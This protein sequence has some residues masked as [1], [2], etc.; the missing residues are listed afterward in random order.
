M[1]SPATIVCAHRGASRI[2]P[3]NSLAAFEAAIA[4]GAEMIETDVRAD[5]SGRLVL[6]HDPVSARDAGL[7]TLAELLELARGRIG[8]DLELKEPPLVEAVL[9][10]TTARAGGLMVPSCS[11]GGLLGAPAIDPALRTGLLVARL[12]RVDP[13]AAAHA[14]GASLL[15]VQESMLGDRL[16]RRADLPLWVWTVND[17]ARLTRC[18]A[19]PAVTGVITDVPALAVE[20]RAGAGRGD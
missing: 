9:K 13:I 10:Q 5:R 2:H 17:R 1:S 3:D 4:S 19:E 18:L 20:L 6:S 8:L 12:H 14:C 11:R 7:V 15:L 16:L